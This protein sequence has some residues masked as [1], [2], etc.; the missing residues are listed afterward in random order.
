MADYQEHLEKI[1]GLLKEN[2]RGLNI[3]EI[4]E[5]IGVSKVSMAKYLDV[6]AAEGKIE[7]RVMGKAKIFYVIQISTP[8]SLLNHIPSMI[9]ILDAD[10][11]VI[12]A[13]DHFLKYCSLSQKQVF[14]QPLDAIPRGITREPA[15]LRALDEVFRTRDPVADLTVGVPYE[16][17]TFRVTLKGTA[18][19]GDRFS[20]LVIINDITGQKGGVPGK[21]RLTEDLAQVLLEDIGVPACIVQSGKIQLVNARFAAMCGD[22]REDLLFCPFLEFVHPEDLERVRAG[23]ERQIAGGKLNKPDFFRGI[24]KSGAGAGF[25]VQS[26]PFSWKQEPATLNFCIDPTERTNHDG[27]EQRTPGSSG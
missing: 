5:L 26:V 18:I 2:P 13:N 24:A 20:I 3:R 9:L 1:L 10:A 25:D 27:I 17:K 21:P 23:Y 8:P 16:E 12:Q 19:A 15:F 11:R 14:G 4:A 7:V 6:L 22:S